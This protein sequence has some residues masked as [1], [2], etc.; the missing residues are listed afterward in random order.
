M[1]CAMSLSKRGSA[2]LRHSYL[3]TAESVITAHQASA[4][5]SNPLTPEAD[6]K[7]ALD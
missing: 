3:G 5:T 2:A 4:F 1:W 7:A 6:H